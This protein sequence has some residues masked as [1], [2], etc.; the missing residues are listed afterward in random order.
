MDF[1]PI[2]KKWQERWEK[3][4]VYKTSIDKSKPKFFM[5]FAYP[6]VSGFLHVGHMRGYTYTD[7]ITR[8]K[9]MRG[10]N[11]LFPVGVHASGN[12]AI[13]FYQ[14]VKN[15]DPKWIEYLKENGATDEDLNKMTSPEAVVDY[16][17]NV[18]VNEYW[19]KFGFLADWKRFTCTIYP[20][21]NKFIQWQFRKLKEKGLIVQKPYYATFCPKCG[22]VAV[23]PSQTDISKGG[24]AEKQ[25]FTLLKFKMGDVYLI[26]ATL[27]PETVYGQTNMWVRPDITYVKI[28][29]GD[30]I[31][32]VSREAAEKLKYQKEGIEIV[33]EVKGEELIGKKALAPGVNREIIILPSS[34]VDPNFGTGIVTSVPSDAPYD[35]IA[36]EDLKKDE[37]TLRKYGIDPEEVRSIQLI[38]IIETP[39]WGKFPAK[40]IVEKM[41]I[42]NQNDP[43][44][45]EATQVIYK[46]GFHKG[47][48]IGDT[49]YSGMSVEEAKEKV[50]QDL[51]NQGLADIMYELSEEVICRC[52]ERVVIKL[53]PDAWFIK[54]SDEELT[55]K[56]KEHAKT[57]LILPETFYNNFPN[58]L[59]WFQDRACARLGNWLG[60]KLPFDERWV[61]EPIS[62]S[63]LY[64]AFYIV[65]KYVNLGKI[66]VEDLTD[67]FFDYVFLG[68]GE[69]KE[70]W[71]P[72]REEFDYWYPLDINLGG[73]EHQTVH[74]PVFVMNHVAILPKDKWPKGIIAHWYIT[75]KGGKISKSK[76]GAEPIPGATKKYSVDGMRLYYC[77]VASPFVDVEWDPDTVLKYKSQ[78]EKLFT[79]FETLLKETSGKENKW[80]VSRF[81]S[82]LKQATEAMDRYDMR[83]TIDILLFEFMKDLNKYI[84]QGVNLKTSKEILNLWLRTLAPFIPHTAEELWERLGNNSF[85]SLESWPEVDESKIDPELEAS[86]ELIDRV[87][88][89][90]REVIKLVGKQPSKIKIFVSPQWKYEFLSIV[91]DEIKNGNR[92]FKSIISKIPQELKPH[93]PEITKILPKL[94]K[95]ESKIPTTILSEDKEYNFLTENKA[96]LSKEFNAEIEIVK[97]SASSEPKAKQAFP[98]KPGILIE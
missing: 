60:T 43:K 36:L 82:K 58:I 89:D 25:E 64:P 78:V 67:E 29:V 19:K 55:K 68:K 87:K 77:H 32:V 7:V 61:I 53:I 24:N 33:G 44:L 79:L 23:D 5:I 83:K 88:D 17:V 81:Y 54:Y 27:R 46:E 48:M 80:I 98:S 52:G 62:D 4:G 8:Y 49:P 70:E 73:K 2:E 57:M 39:G 40:E 37:E 35:Y 90:I 66:K 86:V 16:F 65:S 31:W 76:G 3:E 47:K 75:G 69:G 38:P 95:D 97:A 71:K 14:K 84:K 20:E 11:V 85:V 59:D 1:E 6:G 50:K 10:Y 96:I 94:I 72:I 34:F 22:P 12:I 9:R 13:A 63:T 15:K 28:K 21:Y 26:A 91:K 30:E 92:D 18:Y 45:K 56:S 41:G 51:I 74:F 42:K 93:M